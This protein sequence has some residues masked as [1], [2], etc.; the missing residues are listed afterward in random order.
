MTTTRVKDKLH[1]NF[2]SEFLDQYTAFKEGDTVT[3]TISLFGIKNTSYFYKLPIADKLA[4]VTRL[5]VTAGEF[6]KVG[7]YKKAAK[8]YQ[9]VNGYFNFGDTGNNYTKEDE[10]SEHFKKTTEDLNALKLTSFTN[11]VVCKF[12][13][14]EHQSVVAIT[15]QIIEMAPNHQKAL[16]FRGKSQIQTE[17][18]DEAIKTLTHLTEIASDNNDFKTE[19]ARAKQAKANANKKQQQLYSKMFK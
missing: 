11:L 12:K 4:Y 5:K 6:F 7:N 9:K 19:L 2:K 15:D 3:F 13:L 8:I 16:F 10:E 17:E 14:K 1:T 18:Y